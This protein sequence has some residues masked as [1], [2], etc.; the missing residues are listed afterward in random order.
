[1]EMIKGLGIASL[2]IAVI[3]IFIPL[4]G[5]WMAFFALGLV[6]F[7]ALLGDRSIPVAVSLIS[8]VNFYFLT[9]S[10]WFNNEL[11]KTGNVTLGIFFFPWSGVCLFMAA[12][13]LIAI[14]L[15]A[16]GIKVIQKKKSEVPTP[17]PSSNLPD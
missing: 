8:F 15:N 13:P 7:S 9:P 14:A 16:N 1:M 4:V 12:L 3:A 10:L 17:L 6:T 11:A 5:I 2:V